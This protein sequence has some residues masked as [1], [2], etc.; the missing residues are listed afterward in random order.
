MNQ[1]YKQV[2]KNTGMTPRSIDEAY[3]TPDYAYPIQRFKSEYDDFKDFM[4]GMFIWAVIAGL[5]FAMFYGIYV[6]LQ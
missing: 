4:V 3:K 1:D 2:Y 5:A 6:W